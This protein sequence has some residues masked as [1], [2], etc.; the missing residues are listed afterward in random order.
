MNIVV[1]VDV[2]IR[3][4]Y[5]AY[6]H[7]DENATDKEIIESLTDAIIDNQ[8]DVLTP[9]LDL[10]IENEDIVY[11]EIDYDGSWTEQE[12]RELKEILSTEL[13]KLERMK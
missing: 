9:D 4:Y 6:A 2:C 3:R 11:M 8:D 1:P 10:E 7:V 12:D 5:R 13:P